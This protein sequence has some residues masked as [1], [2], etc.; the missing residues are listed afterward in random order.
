MDNS[1]T[2]GGSVAKSASMSFCNHIFSFIRVKASQAN[3][4]KPHVLKVN[5]HLIEAY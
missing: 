5:K 2:G 4:H 1:L 3:R